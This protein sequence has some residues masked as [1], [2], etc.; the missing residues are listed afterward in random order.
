MTRRHFGSVK[1]RR[2][3]PESFL[4]AD[5]GDAP[6]DDS[7]TDKELVKDRE[8]QEEI[9]SR[10]VDVVLEASVPPEELPRESFFDSLGQVTQQGESPPEC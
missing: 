6:A 1:A 10:Q 9:R 3:I 8:Q 5:G 7:A 4:R 2:A